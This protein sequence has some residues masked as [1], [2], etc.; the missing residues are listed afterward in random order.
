MDARGRR[1]QR[2][3][4]VDSARGQHEDLPWQTILR[5]GMEWAP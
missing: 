5:D 3:A 4:T 2:A 1:E